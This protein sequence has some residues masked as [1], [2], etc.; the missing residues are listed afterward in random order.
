MT[1]SGSAQP[2]RKHSKDLWKGSRTQ[3]I[4]MKGMRGRRKRRKKLKAGQAPSS[5]SDW[6]DDTLGAPA[7]AAS[8][9]GGREAG[10]GLPDMDTQLVFATDWYSFQRGVGETRQVPPPKEGNISTLGAKV[11]ASS[12]VKTSF[13]AQF[14][15]KRSSARTTSRTSSNRRFFALRNVL[16]HRGTFRR[17]RKVF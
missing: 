6:D 7:P 9:A 13:A 8:D 15:P 5:P 1:L 4:R 17:R 2:K 3:G 11:D 10:H 16:Q 14:I 12:G